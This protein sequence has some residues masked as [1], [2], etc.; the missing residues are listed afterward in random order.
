MQNV[1][2]KPRAAGA[3]QAAGQKRRGGHPKPVDPSQGLGIRLPGSLVR[4]LD[5][6]VERQQL[7]EP[8]FS[9]NELIR[10]AIEW[11]IRAGRR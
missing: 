3:G 7:R 4:A 9:R 5:E 8:A 6:V 2:D 10:R 1:I 11:Y